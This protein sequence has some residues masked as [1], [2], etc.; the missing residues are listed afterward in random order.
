MLPTERLVYQAHAARK[1]QPFP[2]GVRL[3]VWPIVNVEYWDIARAMARSVLPPPMGQPRLPDIPN[4]GWHEYGMRR[5]FWRLKDAL[6]ARGIIPTLSING[7]VCEAYPEVAGAAREAGWE[8]MGHSYKQA[9]MHDLDD[10]IAEIKKTSDAIRA[11]TGKAPVGW[12]GPGLTETEDTLDHLS[13]AG[14]E[15]VGDWVVDDVPVELKTASGKPMA[16]LPYT[17]EL[18][19]IS[20]MIQNY[21]TGEFE[22]RCKDQFERLY[23]E[24]ETEPRILSIA[25]H[26]YISGVPH[27]IKYYERAFDLFSSK[28]G[29][30]FWTGEQILNWYRCR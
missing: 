10:Q 26:P 30:A 9:P 27:R 13:D 20:I 15:Y 24:A 21:P 1:L 18:N 25:V 5:G 6:D 2:E 19:D 7:Y 16:G 28:L 4:W 11:F 22:K 12:L 17:L 3:V 8:F 23:D 29:V 14:F